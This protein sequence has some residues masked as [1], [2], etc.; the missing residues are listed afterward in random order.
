M[1]ESLTLRRTVNKVRVTFKT[2]FIFT[3]LERRFSILAS[4]TCLSE[5]DKQQVFK[6]S[7]HK[8]ERNDFEQDSVDSVNAHAPF[9]PKH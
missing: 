8:E 6:L 5:K 7:R 2:I 9:S 3:I 4:T 1:K